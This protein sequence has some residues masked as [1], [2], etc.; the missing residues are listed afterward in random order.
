MVAGGSNQITEKLTVQGAAPD[1][2]YY[3]LEGGTLT[4][5]D[6]YVGAG[7]FFQ[8]TSGNIVQSGLLTLDQGEWNAAAGTQSLGPLQL[9]GGPSTNSSISFT[10]GSSILRL[11]NS[12]A[13]PWDSTAILYITNWH[14]SVSGDGETQLFFGSDASG[15]TLQQLALIKFSLAGGLYPARLLPTGELVPQMGLLTSSISGGTL[16]LTWGASWTLQS[17]TN[18]AGPYE[19]VQGANNPFTTSMTNPGQFFRLRQ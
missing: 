18:A 5:K 13:Q 8:H 4:V 1:A 9:T 17:S 15:L 6:I 12:S 11:A 14:G 3:T 19:D 2:F 16:T 7:A 10:N